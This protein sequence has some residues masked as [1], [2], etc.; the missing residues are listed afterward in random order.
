MAMSPSSTGHEGQYDTKYSPFDWILRA[1]F[2]GEVLFHYFFRELACSMRQKMVL[3]LPLH[4]SI[5]LV[6]MFKECAC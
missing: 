4:A 5:V 6:L 1:A 3:P 2:A